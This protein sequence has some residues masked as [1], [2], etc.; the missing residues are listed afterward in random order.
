MPTRAELTFDRILAAVLFV[1]AMLS[2]ALY[3]QMGVFAHPA[4]MWVGVL[5]SLGMCAPLAWRRLYP[6]SV[7]FASGG[8]F[9]VAALLSVSEQ[10]IANVCLFLAIYTV[11]AVVENRDRARLMRVVMMSGMLVF[12]VVGLYIQVM[13][14]NLISKIPQVGALSPLVA[15]LLAQI[16]INV[17][18]FAGAY[19]MG[20]IAFRVRVRERELRALTEELERERA[21]GARQAVVL[22]RVRI[23][24]ELHDVVAHH[25]SLMGVQ[26]GAAR[27]VLDQDPVAARTALHQVEDSARLAISELRGLLGTLREADLALDAAPPST[28]GLSA[29]PALIRMSEDAGLPTRFEIQGAEVPV[30][31][32][33][34]FTLYRIAQE[35]LTNAR[36][37]G[38]QAATADVRLRYLDD[39]VE[40]EIGNTGAMPVPRTQ[41]GHGQLGMRERIAAAGGR[42]E[43]GPR[44]RGGYLVRAFIPTLGSSPSEGITP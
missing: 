41:T 30:S 25:V 5:T 24:R 43:Y 34:G 11:G 40:L 17:L 19:I 22:E 18:Y 36:K 35:S 27:F 14:P 21:R 15:F 31:D 29:L 13:D 28:V 7:M 32:L 12:L 39:G 20:E 33:T 2:L 4:P 10:L 44:S 23:A 9:V 1:C 37:H 42:L 26:A 8:L 16:L 38:G 3:Q 6:V